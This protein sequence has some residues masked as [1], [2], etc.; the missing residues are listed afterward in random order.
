MNFLTRARAHCLLVLVIL[1]VQN[2]RAAVLVGD[3]RVEGSVDHDVLGQAEAFPT[4]ASE[5]GTINAVSVYIDTSNAAAQIFAGIYSDGGGAPGKLLGSGSTSYLTNGAWNTVQVAPASVTRGDR[6]WIAI[7]STGGGPIAFRDKV[8][9]CSSNTSM[10][11]NL[12]A[13]PVTWSAGTNWAATCPVSAYGFSNGVLSV[14]PASLNFGNLK[15]GT[16]S[17]LSVVLSNSGSTDLTINNIGISGAGYTIAGIAAPITLR[18]MGQSVFSVTFSPTAVN[19]AGGFVTITSDATDSPSTIALSGAGDNFSPS[20]WPPATTPAQIDSGDSNGVE[21][22]VRFQ[23]ATDGLI[24]GIRF[25]KSAA[26]TGTHI[27]NLW[28]NLGVQ[29]ATAPFTAETASGWQEVTFAS[30]VPISANTPYVASYY[31]PN[32]RY[33]D[34]SGYFAISGFTNGNLAAYQDSS[35]TPNGLYNYGS[36]STFPSNSYGSTNYWVDVAFSPTGGGSGTLVANPSAPQLGELVYGNSASQ[37]V[38]ISNAGTAP[39]TITAATVNGAGFS[40]GGLN[41]PTT[42]AP[43]A[44]VTLEVT[45]SPEASGSYTGTLTLL[46]S[47]SNSSV[48]LPLFGSGISPGAGCGCSSDTKTV[49]ADGVSYCLKYRAPSG[50]ANDITFRFD[51]AYSCGQYATGDYFVVA[52]P[53][54]TANITEMSPD[55][56]S[57]PDGVPNG[58]LLNGAEVNPVPSEFVNFDSRLNGY[59]HYPSPSTAVS[60]PLPYSAQAGDSVVKYVSYV[61]PDLSDPTLS[62]QGSLTLLDGVTQVQT[63]TCGQ[64]A[65]VLTVLGSAPSNPG[66]LF[67]PPYAGTGSYKQS[68]STTNLQMQLLGALACPT[69]LDLPVSA[70][71]GIDA[72]LAQAWTKGLR[73]NYVSD[74]LINDEIAPMDNIPYGRSWSTDIWD[75]DTLVLSWLNLSGVCGLSPCTAEDDLEAKLPALIGE[76]QYGV[77]TW[78]AVKAGADFSRGGGGNGGGML[79]SFVFAATMLNN[80]QMLSDLAAANILHYYESQSVFLP[81]NGQMDDAGNELALWGQFGTESFYWSSAISDTHSTNRDPYGFIDGGDQDRSVDGEYLEGYQ[82]DTA[83]PHKYTALLMRLMPSLAANWPNLTAPAGYPPVGAVHNA[84]AMLNYAD[85]WV[86]F[87]RWTQ[88]DQCASPA[89]GGGPNGSGGCVLG[90]SAPYGRFPA[91]NGQ[92]A[93]VSNRTQPF[94]EEMWKQFR[95]CSETCSCTGQAACH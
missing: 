76:V 71:Q 26:N 74:S 81:G 22:G 89:E 50:S 14:Q 39:L 80:S 45:F 62:C 41:L 31:A 34:S 11:T 28:T 75:Y 9:S 51:H 66:I 37:P 73:L 77:D 84:T 65:A 61:N 55:P 43:G 20:I 68:F 56:T 24:T 54:G 58:A 15:V 69:C 16:S 8:G 19:S 5:T 29:L 1:M 82:G 46:S 88:P 86:R 27:G 2:T 70:G 92:N 36:T 91:A 83:A 17:T 59:Q 57:A 35:T 21:L 13:L 10:Q 53:T 12:T 49:T 67:R 85:R 42:V 44:S 25:Y 6:L 18:P 95:A 90:T 33:S 32:G 23:S 93:N 7:L 72:S 3:R 94:G 48:V 30:P 40:S 63:K 52:G 38:T 64:F 78:G 47:A 60:L 87:G 4:T 79:T